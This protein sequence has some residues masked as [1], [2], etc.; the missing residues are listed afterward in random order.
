MADFLLDIGFYEDAIR[1]YYETI[2]LYSDKM[3]L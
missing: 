1:S 3:N 2:E